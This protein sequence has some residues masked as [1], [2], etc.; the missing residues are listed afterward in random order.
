MPNPEF[1]EIPADG[2]ELVATNVIAGQIHKARSISGQ[3]LQT[4]VL[5]GEDAPEGRDKGV[6]A[7]IG[8]YTEPIMASEGID[9]YIWADQDG[10]VR[11]DV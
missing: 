9:V 10:R 4:Y 2:W 11:V 6:P 3:Y 8:T 5:T 1:K 7:F